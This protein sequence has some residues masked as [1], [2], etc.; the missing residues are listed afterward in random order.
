VAAIHQSKLAGQ[1]GHLPGNIEKVLKQFLQPIIQWEILLHRFFSDLLDENVT[2]SRPNRRYTDMYLPSKFTDDGRLAKLNYYMDVSG[3]VSD[4]DVLRF[5]SEV[6]H[7]KDTYNPE[8][9]NLVQFDTRI[10][11]ETRITESDQFNEIKIVGRG[12]TALEPVRQHINEHKPTAAIIFSDLFCTPM[13]PL[14]FDIPIIWVAV[15][16]RSATVPFGQLIHIKGS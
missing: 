7:V 15:G 12:G 5:N 1:A 8:E 10:T 13:A 2:W 6:K 11:S 4:S 3:S 9:M 16:N 14:D